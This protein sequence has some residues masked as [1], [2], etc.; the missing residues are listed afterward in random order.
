MMTLTI[1]Q[2][3][4]FFIYIYISVFSIYYQQR[5]D[6][7]EL[8]ILLIEMTVWRDAIGWMDHSSY[9]IDSFVE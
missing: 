3:L 5:C 1:Y 4:L 9:V 7:V 2:S 6:S 8:L